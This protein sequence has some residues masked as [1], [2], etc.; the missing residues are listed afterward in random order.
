MLGE[1]GWPDHAP[2]DDGGREGTIRSVVQVIVP[3]ASA[4]CGGLPQLTAACE[5]IVISY[6]VVALWR[7]VSYRIVLAR[8]WRPVIATLIA[9][10][11]GLALGADSPYAIALAIATFVLAVV[12]LH[13][14]AGG[15]H[16]SQCLADRSA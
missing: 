6:A 11:V 7:R 12:A 4:P 5:L 3:D 2:R 8:V 9:A 14:W 16:S 10:V 13:A 15:A 1:H